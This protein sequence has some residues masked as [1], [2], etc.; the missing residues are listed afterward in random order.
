MA[1]ALVRGAATALGRLEE[2]KPAAPAAPPAAAP[3]PP[4]LPPLPP[5][6]VVPPP[7]LSPI[8]APPAPPPARELDK[9]PVAPAPAPTPP[10]P[11]PDH[12]P[13][14]A[15]P[16]LART[17]PLKDL[18]G[19]PPRPAEPEPSRRQEAAPRATE[20]DEVA[21]EE[22]DH[23]GETAEEE[24]RDA[25]LHPAYAASASP[26]SGRLIAIAA[27]AA[28]LFAGGLAIWQ[29]DALVR[30][31]EPGAEDVAQAPQQATRSMNVQIETLGALAGALREPRLIHSV[32]A[33]ERYLATA[34][35][36]GSRRLI[37]ALLEEGANPLSD[38]AIAGAALAGGKA[39]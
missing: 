21:P 19:K 2:P 24:H 38:L 28:L 6:P 22:A 32:T 25:P 1:E 13:S 7:K 16:V 3:K 31:L 9:D 12:A 10:P 36:S 17:N 27:G 5:R 23:A 20:P 37:Q 34:N 30:L 15:P 18:A 11:A 39:A 33:L 4:G 14:R 35:Q 29:R 8:K 26:V